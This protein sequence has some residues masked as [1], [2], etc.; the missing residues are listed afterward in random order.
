MLAAARTWFLRMEPTYRV[1]RPSGSKA[2]IS[3]KGSG[4]DR[5]RAGQAAKAVS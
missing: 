2:E 4:R 5:V 3:V 1:D